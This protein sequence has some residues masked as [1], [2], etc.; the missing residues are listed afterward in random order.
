MVEEYNKNFLSDQLDY[1]D[2]LVADLADNLFEKIRKDGILASYIERDKDVRIKNNLIDISTTPGNN[3][4]E[5][6]LSFGSGFDG[7]KLGVKNSIHINIGKVY[8]FEFEFV[9]KNII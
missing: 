4:D 1:N 5:E 2:P 9:L 6:L 7:E 8:N 3:V